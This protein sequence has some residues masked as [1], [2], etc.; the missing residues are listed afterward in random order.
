MKYHGESGEGKKREYQQRIG[1]ESDE[2]RPLLVY[3]QNECGFV[4]LVRMR[5]ERQDTRSY[6]D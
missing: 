2:E 6:T 5:G 1:N 3:F 4:H